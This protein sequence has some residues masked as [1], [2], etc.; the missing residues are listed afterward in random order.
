MFTEVENVASS[1]KISIYDLVKRSFDLLI[2]CFGCLFILPIS[3]IVKIIY[4]SSGDYDSI[5]Y[6]QIRIGKD[7]KKCK[8]N[9]TDIYFLD[10]LQCYIKS[11]SVW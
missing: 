5:F 2:G 8:H 11:N 1:K 9:N 4:I 6:K 10:I 7:G 3:L